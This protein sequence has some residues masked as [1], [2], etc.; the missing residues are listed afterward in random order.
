M[1]LLQK[2]R[3]TPDT[4]GTGYSVLY[5]KANGRWYFKDD[6]G[7]E[8]AMGPV[9]RRKTADEPVTSSTTLQDDDHLVFPIGANEEWVADYSISVG[10]SISTSGLKVVI[11]SPATAIDVSATLVGGV[12]GECKSGHIVS[13]VSPIEFT[14]AEFVSSGTGHLHISA[15]FLNGA[16][17]GSVTLRFA[18]ETSSGTAIVFLKGSRMVAHQ[19][20]P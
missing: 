14:A 9:L 8:H 19:I 7:V 20:I 2:E 18:Q 12:F 3:A 16:T 6:E 17:P 11:T 1:G 4:P 10:G 5:P 15:W 13:A